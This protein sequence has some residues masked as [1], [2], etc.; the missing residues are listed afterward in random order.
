MKSDLRKFGLSVGG[1]FAVLGAISRYRGHEI[2]PVVLATLG[3][4]LIVP[5]ALA[6]TLLGPARSAWMRGAAAVGHFNT[7][8][9]LGVF[10]YLV[11]TPIGFVMRLVRDPLNRAM[12][13]GAD[14]NWTL[15]ERKPVDAASYQQQF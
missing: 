13:D 12:D 4:L 11:L 8:V 15:R 1:A 10:F 14:S 5:G 6:P 2:A 9:I 7:Q 3:V